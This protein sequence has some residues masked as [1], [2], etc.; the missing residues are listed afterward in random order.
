MGRKG[1]FYF[2]IFLFVAVQF[3]VFYA[4]DMWKL[5]YNNKVKL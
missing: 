1:F 4:L 5:K 3:M 2:C